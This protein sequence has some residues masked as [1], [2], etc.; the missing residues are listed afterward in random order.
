[1]KKLTILCIAMASCG[2]SLA[3]EMGRVLSSTPVIAQ[4]A[5]PRSVCNVEQVAVQPPKSGAGALMGA[6]AGGAVGNSIGGGGGK[7]AATMIGIMGGAIVGDSIEG[8]PAA[9]FQNVQRCHTQN[10]Y[11]NRTVAYNVVYE[12]AGKQYSVQMPNDPGPNIQLQVS[13]VG[14]VSQ[15]TTPEPV[16]TIIT[17]P[18]Y[19]V[20]IERPYYPPVSVDLGFG[21][22]GG[23]GAHRHWR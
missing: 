9:Q 17:Q 23:Y 2:L 4:V 6:I 12:Y 15:A 13:P 22:W 21:Y 5:Q 7:A 8:A 16:T 14:V 10:F 18:Q 11:E 3:Q 20:Y 19:P 1:M